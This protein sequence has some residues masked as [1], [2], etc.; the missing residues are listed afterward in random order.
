ML[1]A[2]GDNRAMGLTQE[3]YAIQLTFDFT[4]EPNR[5]PNHK[6]LAQPKARSNHAEHN[7]RHKAMQ[8]GESRQAK[9][10]GEQHHY[11][12]GA[13]WLVYWMSLKGVIHD[14]H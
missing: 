6:L 5:P 7:G 13:S 2:A 9:A 10:K 3:H 12:A 11:R 1:G 14:Q 4:L 8:A